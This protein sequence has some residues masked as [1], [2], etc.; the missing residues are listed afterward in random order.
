MFEKIKSFLNQ[1]KSQIEE[2][3]KNYQNELNNYHNECMLELRN[4]LDLISNFEIL[5]TV[6]NDSSQGKLIEFLKEAKN[7]H[8]KFEEAH[9]DLNLKPNPAKFTSISIQKEAQNI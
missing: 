7:R 9:K 5:T 6:D 4:H 3:Q 8:N 2:K 1:R